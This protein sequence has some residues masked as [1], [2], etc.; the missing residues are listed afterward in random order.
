MFV[1]QGGEGMENKRQKDL[2][3]CFYTVELNHYENERPISCQEGKKS[4]AHFISKE[5]DEI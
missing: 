5:E 1:L 4:D 2:H 3:N